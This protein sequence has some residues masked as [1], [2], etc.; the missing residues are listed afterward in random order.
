MK[1]PL[2]V[3]AYKRAD[4][5]KNCLEALACTDGHEDTDLYIFADGARG[6]DDTE[7]VNRVRFLISAFAEK[8]SFRS[9]H[10]RTSEVNRGLANSVISGVTEVI[11][12]YG[13]VIVV[14]DDLTVTGDFLTLMNRML[15]Y[16]EHEDNVWSVTGFSEPIKALKKYKHDIYYGYRGCSYGWGTW[17]DRWDTVDWDVNGY[18]E[19]LSDRKMQRRFNRG[20]SDMVRMLKD[21]MEGII[22]SWAI[23]WCFSQSLQDKY[24]VFPKETFVINTGRDGSGTNQGTEKVEYMQH[25]SGDPVKL[26]VLGIDRRVSQSFYYAHS[27]LIKKIKRNMNI[28]GIRRQLERAKITGRFPK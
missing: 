22:D 5:L 19:L 16:Y 6:E 23:R 13:K 25:K 24:T 11:N 4:K 2:I 12:T 1:A 21:Q 27:D 26:E 20:G 7:G 14:E 10:V 8:N 15:D 18:D 3:F 9:V 28:K 17:K